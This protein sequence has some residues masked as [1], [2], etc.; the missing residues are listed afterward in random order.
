MTLID[1]NGPYL[2]Q[3]LYAPDYRALR[4]PSMLF[5]LMHNTKDLLPAPTNKKSGYTVSFLQ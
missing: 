4:T 1:S 3:G 5:V 2:S